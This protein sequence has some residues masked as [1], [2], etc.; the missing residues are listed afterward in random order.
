MK[1]Y[2]VRRYGRSI[3]TMLIVR[4]VAEDSATGGAHATDR[5]IVNRDAILELI[6]EEKNPDRREQAIRR[7]LSEGCCLIPFGDLPAAAG[8]EFPLQPAAQRDGQGHDTHHGIGYGLCPR[9]G[10]EAQI[11]QRRSIFST[12]TTTATR[13][14]RICR[15]IITSG[16][17]SCWQRCPRM[18]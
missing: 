9:R 2:L 4:W 10:T 18:P 1:R 8:R 14:W 15:W 6:A 12:T 7:Q 17:W 11:R 13:S 3:D 5:E 16:R